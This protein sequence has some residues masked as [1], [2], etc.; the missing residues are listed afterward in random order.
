[1]PRLLIVDDE[2]DI[3][4][5]IQRVAELMGFEV[6]RTSK[7]RDF[8]AV[9]LSNRPDAVVIDLTLPDI[10]GVQLTEWL[11]VVGP[12]SLV[13]LAS[14]LPAEAFRLLTTKAV[15]SSLTTVRLRKPVS[16]GELVAALRPLGQ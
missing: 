14:D 2:D 16:S 1:M 15:P 12:P 13:I 11:D 10:T 6:A 8:Q 9:Y 4:R 5:E 3:G 7:G